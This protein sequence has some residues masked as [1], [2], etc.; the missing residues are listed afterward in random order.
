MIAMA[1]SLAKAL[2]HR[3]ISVTAVAPGF[4]ETDMAAETL[5]GPQGDALRAESPFGRV[6]TP[7]EVAAAVVFLA[8]PE[9]GFST[10]TVVDVNGAS[11]LRM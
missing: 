7:E 5:A 3:Q 1:Q 8:S 6:A 9:A 2:G 4:V 11:F 10:G